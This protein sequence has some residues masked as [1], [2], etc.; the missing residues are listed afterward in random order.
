MLRDVG[1]CRPLSDTVLQGL[2]SPRRGHYC[3]NGRRDAAGAA[4]TASRMR[5]HCLARL[6]WNE[7]SREEARGWVDAMLFF[8]RSCLD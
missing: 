5:E 8:L 2:V 3:C 4:A 7:V 6:D 1:D